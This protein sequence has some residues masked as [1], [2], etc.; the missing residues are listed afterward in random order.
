[1]DSRWGQ[2]SLIKL[3]KFEN[4]DSSLYD[5]DSTATSMTLGALE[6]FDKIMPGYKDQIDWNDA[7]D[8]LIQKDD[9]ISISFKENS[10]AEQRKI[11]QQRQEQFRLQKRQSREK[12]TRRPSPPPAPLPRCFSSVILDVKPEGRPFWSI[13]KDTKIDFQ[14]VDPEVLE[15]RFKLKPKNLT[16]VIPLAKQIHVD[17][18]KV[19]MASLEIYENIMK[20][21][22][23]SEQRIKIPEDDFTNPEKVNK[24]TSTL[25][26]PRFV[27]ALSDDL[28]SSYHV[29][30]ENG[31]NT[32]TGP[33]LSTKE[34][35][36]DQQWYQFLQPLLDPKAT[37][38]TVTIKEIHWLKRNQG[39]NEAHHGMSSSKTDLQ[40]H[41]PPGKL[42]IIEG[43]WEFKI[44]I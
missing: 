9:K 25:V 37:E 10:F 23:Y 32:H 15:P 14:N 3:S 29:A 11:E 33:D 42:V 6:M 27:I 20:L 26:E 41:H 5:N 31:G 44:P 43:P 16:R 24:I 18:I 40:E 1:M 22:F 17:G 39:V 8:L 21:I 2:T 28:G 30:F 34:A 13:G 19:I 38:L 7:K 36:S 4:S 35:V 12:G